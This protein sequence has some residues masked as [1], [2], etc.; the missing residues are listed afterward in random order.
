[1]QAGYALEFVLV[2][3]GKFRSQPLALLIVVT[4]RSE[5]ETN[6]RAETDDEQQAPVDVSRDVA[7]SEYLWVC[8]DAT[9]HS[10]AANDTRVL[11]LRRIHRPAPSH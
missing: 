2:D 9:R 1:M 11:S 3:S 5:R 7:G 8:L 4:F 6:E 10:A